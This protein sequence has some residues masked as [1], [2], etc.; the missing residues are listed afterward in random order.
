MA[1]GAIHIL[2]KHNLR[3]PEDVSIIGYDNEEWTEFCRPPL[4]TISL[5]FEQMGEIAA[6]MLIDR[7]EGQEHNNIHQDIILQPTLIERSSCIAI[8]H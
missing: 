7:I 6:Q 2:A 1:M 4:T 8:T 3:V 5:P